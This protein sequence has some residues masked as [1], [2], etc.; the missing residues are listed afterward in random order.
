MRLWPKR[1]PATVDAQEVAGS[2]A[3]AR[4]PIITGTSFEFSPALVAID[5]QVAP[6]SQAFRA[7]ALELL[8]RHVRVGRRALALCGVSSGDGV[9]FTVANL[10]VALAKVSVPTLLIEANLREPTLERLIR[11]PMDRGG[12][13]QLLRSDAHL[14]TAIHTSALPNLS[15][16][17]AGGV[18]EDS[19][20]LV[21]GARFMDLLDECMRHYPLT[22]IDTPP[23]NRSADGRVIAIAAQYA[24]VVARRNVTFM[25]DALLLAQ[26]LRQDGVEIVGTVYNEA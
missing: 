1:R 3:S 6:G 18:A 20:E 25:D 16:L 26:H 22:L 23:A 12:V 4:S 13:Q 15:I 19:S 17:Y 2:A 11:P 5:D 21:A 7:M 9:T 10:A 14:T 24:V 8:E